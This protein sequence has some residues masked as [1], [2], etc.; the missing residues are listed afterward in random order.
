MDHR[1]P[2]SREKC[3]KDLFSASTRPRSSKRSHRNQDLRRENSRRPYQAVDAL[4]QVRIQWCYPVRSC[5][6]V[7]REK[8]EK[9]FHSGVAFVPRSRVGRDQQTTGRKDMG[10]H[11]AIEL[12]VAFEKSAFEAESRGIARLGLVPRYL[13]PW[14]VRFRWV[15]LWL[16]LYASRPSSRVRTNVLTRQSGTDDGPGTLAPTKLETGNSIRSRNPVRRLFSFQCFLPQKMNVPSLLPVTTSMEPSLF[17][18]VASTVE[19][20]PERVSIS[21]GSNRAPPGALGSRTVLYQ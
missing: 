5:R 20:T 3:C 6:D 2:A 21:S 16:C 12:G 10:R 14:W 8:C 7:S 15:S 17:R 4:G 18:S 9:C 19:P 1:L 13:R 11:L